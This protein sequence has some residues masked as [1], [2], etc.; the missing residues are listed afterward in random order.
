LLKQLLDLTHIAKSKHRNASYL[1][2]KILGV[3]KITQ[4][5]NREIWA[6][7][8]IQD[9]IENSDIDWSKSISKIIQH[10]FK[11]N[12]HSKKKLYLLKKRFCRWIKSSVYERRKKK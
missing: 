4:G 7:V 1:A 9:F 3:L 6:K 10:L 5:N 11:K 2:Q 8:P 12:Q